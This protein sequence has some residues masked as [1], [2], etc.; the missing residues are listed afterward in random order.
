[1]RKIDPNIIAFTLVFCGTMLLIAAMYF[2]SFERH[3]THDWPEQQSHSE[4]KTSPEN[5]EVRRSSGLIDP[6]RPVSDTNNKQYYPAHTNASSLQHYDHK[7]QILMAVFTAIGLVIGG[8]GLWMIY[9]TLIETGS[10]A[11]SAKDSLALERDNSRLELQPYI[12]LQ[13]KGFKK[14]PTTRTSN[15]L[16]DRT[17]FGYIVSVEIKNIGKTPAEN[18][19]INIGSRGTIMM[20]K[21]D[22]K[23]LNY[24]A[25]SIDKEQHMQSMGAI[26][27]GA[28]Y[29]YVREFRL[30]FIVP[31]DE[32]EQFDTDPIKANTRFTLAFRMSI[33]DNFTRKLGELNGRYQR[34]VFLFDYFS[35]T[36]LED[37]T[38]AV[39]ALEVPA[40][41]VDY[42]EEN[43]QGEYVFPLRHQGS[44]ALGIIKP[45]G[46]NSEE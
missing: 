41:A 34:R 23:T 40:E 12:T 2:A 26:S 28:G 8:A 4:S 27:L 15:I 39:A 14:V 11:V 29:S 43:N 24:S 44:G 17:E 13:V 25:T 22:I 7:A 38:A 32:L 10:A 1:M 36:G 6:N 42:P 3:H 5:D 30:S 9:R 45:R 16:G 19:F 46:N 18:M 31:S 21:G 33:T 20:S 37:M 35:F